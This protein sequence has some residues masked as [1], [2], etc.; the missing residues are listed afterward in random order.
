MNYFSP[1][2]LTC[3]CGCGLNI[4]SGK[5][6]VLMNRVREKFGEPIIVTSGSRCKKHNKKVGGSATS[7]HLDGLAMDCR[8]PLPAGKRH[9]LVELLFRFQR[10]GLSKEFFHVDIDPAKKQALWFY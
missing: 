3:R 7:S 2:E 1:E 10:I 9:K 8:M 5:L 4:V 6:V